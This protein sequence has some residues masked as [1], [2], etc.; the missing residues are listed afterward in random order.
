[1]Y[2][3]VNINGYKPFF[4]VYLYIKYGLIATIHCLHL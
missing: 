3:F 2:L 4:L 1:M